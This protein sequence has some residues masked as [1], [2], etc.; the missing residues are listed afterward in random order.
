MLLLSLVERMNW[1]HIDET[2]ADTS[3]R[4]LDMT[5][6]S[7]QATTVAAPGVRQRG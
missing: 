4:L 7:T 2:A 1:L 6:P 3:K 5:P